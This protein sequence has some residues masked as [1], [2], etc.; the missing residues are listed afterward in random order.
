MNDAFVEANVNHG[1]ANRLSLCAQNANTNG[2]V[3]LNVASSLLQILI[4][5]DSKVS[6]VVEMLM[7]HSPIKYFYLLV[8]LWALIQPCFLIEMVIKVFVPNHQIQF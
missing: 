1:R 6:K 7:N 2:S 5:I 3:V 8:V 4:Q